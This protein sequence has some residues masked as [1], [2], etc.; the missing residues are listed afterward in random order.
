MTARRLVFGEVAD[1]YERHRPDYPPALI[2]DLL[3]LAG[4]TA[5]ERAL[6]VGS[7]T[8]KATAMLAARGIAVLGV[9]PSAEMAAVARAKLATTGLV[10]I[11]ECD[12]ERFDPGGERFRLACSAQ[13]W[14]WVDPD[15]R[16]ALAR[17]ALVDGGVLAAFWN[18]P[19]WGAS[20]LRDELIDIYAN[21]APQV[22]TDGPLHPA[23]DPLENESERRW[24]REI[25]AAAGLAQPAHRLYRW[26]A[27]YSSGEYVALLGTLS[28]IRLLAVDVRERLLAGV[29]AA[30]NAHAGV[31]TLPM[32]TRLCTARAIALGR[33][34][35]R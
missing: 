25:V 28:E 12:F 19:A 10:E 15:R 33:P 26:D 8:G 20:T 9:E 6:E 23:N 4:L 14:H 11:V 17:R 21:L 31:L 3:T 13:A 16:C 27:R 2:D 32:A 29:A 5:G 34:S 7:G 24:A 1:A 22:S 18:V 35:D 30:I